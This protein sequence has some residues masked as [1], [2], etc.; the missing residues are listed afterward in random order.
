MA[1]SQSKKMI[2]AISLQGGGARGAYEYGVLKALYTY[3]GS[4][5]SPRVVTGVSIG[6]VNAALLVGAKGDPLA[7]LD[8]LWRERFCVAL[9]TA[10]WLSSGDFFLRSGLSNP[11]AD[12]LEQIFS[13]FG[14][15]GMYSVKPEFLFLP[16][17]ALWQ[18]NSIYD[19][20]LLK[21]TLAEFIDLEK[22]NC[23]EKTRLIITAVDVQSG[24]QIRFDNAKMT[25]TLDHIIA[26]GSFPVTFPMV[27]IGGN[28]YWDGGIFTNLPVGEAVNALE[29]IEP[30][31]A[32]LER[33]IILVS[34]HRAA[35]PLPKTLPEAS[36]R[37]Y[38]LL[39]SGKF[40]LDRKLYS[41]YSA[42]VDAV[43]Q[44]D[45]TLPAESPIRNHEG[46]KDL[47]RHRKIDR[48]TIIGEEGTSAVGSGSDFS[49]K[50]LLARI[51]AGIRDASTLFQKED[52]HGN[53]R[54]R[55]AR[56]SKR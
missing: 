30:D 39:F 2:T 3:R 34:L 6:A 47:M 18:A 46:Y 29:Q 19:T 14:N 45:K 13:I 22:L 40:A 11:F 31:R 54:E 7:A 28:A 16:W 26:S 25:L 37:F 41:K 51:E 20:A 21:K 52:V 50:T 12:W 36:D 5:F 1:E 48:I 17:L 23:P 24:R 53:G 9:P 27:T 10:P 33:E 43:R 4:A 56:S 42:F 35:G 49:R 8:T 15:P 44:I 38:N 55:S 32:D